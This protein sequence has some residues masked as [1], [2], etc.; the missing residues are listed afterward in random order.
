MKRKNTA[1]FLVL[2]AILPLDGEEI[3]VIVDYSGVSSKACDC[4]PVSSAGWRE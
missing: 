4:T 3:K 2:T 1:I